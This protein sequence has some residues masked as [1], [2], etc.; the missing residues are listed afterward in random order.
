MYIAIHT[1]LTAATS[2]ETVDL[3]FLNKASGRGGNI[4]TDC[5]E[6]CLLIDHFGRK[7]AAPGFREQRL[8]LRLRGV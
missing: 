3:R 6:T 7:D 1:H 8:F 4:G 5:R 2:I